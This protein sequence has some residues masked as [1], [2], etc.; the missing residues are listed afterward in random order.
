VATVALL[1][2]VSLVLAHNLAFLAAYG[3]GADAALRATGHDEGWASAVRLVLAISSVLG[4]ATVVRLVQL[5]RTARR[6]ER[7]RR[8]HP[9]TDWRQLARTVLTLWLPLVVAT[10]G[11]FLVQE[12]LERLAIGEAL[13]GIAPLLEGG[14]TGPLLIIPLISLL[15]AGVGGLF[16][17]GITALRARIAAARATPV[18]PQPTRIPAPVDADV[19]RSDVLAH[20][21]GLRAP[22]APLAG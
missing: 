8:L 15:I 12:N 6:L 5:L 13:P 1:S 21:H 20:H 16:R 14:L 19:R 4:V 11:W 17:W 9:R 10:A 18:H 22:P 2:P 3:G 7:D